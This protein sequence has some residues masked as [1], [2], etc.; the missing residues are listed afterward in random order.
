MPWDYKNVIEFKQTLKNLVSLVPVMAFVIL[1]VLIHGGGFMVLPQKQSP[2]TLWCITMLFIWMVIPC[3]LLKFVPLMK[4]FGETEIYYGD[5]ETAFRT[6][7]SKILYYLKFLIIFVVLAELSL[8]LV[9]A[10]IPIWIGSIDIN[11][12]GYRTR[13]IFLTS[14]I[15]LMIP[16]II[17]Q[18]VYFFTDFREEAQPIN[19]DE[20]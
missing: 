11:Q 6:H 18:V 16:N 14:F 15:L 10:D 19:D 3:L 7:Y 2:E 5:K 20:I 17:Y 4:M 12:Y 1:V 9:S 13:I 8:I